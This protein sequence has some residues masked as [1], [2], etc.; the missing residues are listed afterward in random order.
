MTEAEK[1]ELEAAYQRIEQLHKHIEYLHKEL[2]ERKDE[3][4]AAG[5][6]DR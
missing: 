1:H 2:Q 5:R 6:S 4:V 3:Q